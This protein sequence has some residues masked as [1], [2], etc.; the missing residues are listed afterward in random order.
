MALSGRPVRC[1]IVDDSSDFLRAAATV[2]ER[3]GIDVV[4]TAATVAEGMRLAEQ[5]RPDVVLIDV[6]LGDESGFDLAEQLHRRGLLTRS[7]A[8]MTST[9]DSEEFADLISAGPMVGFIPKQ[10]LSAEAIR[11]ARSDQRRE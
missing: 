5:L 9:H 2:L 3:D 8:V 6:Y 7:V 1:L 4:A 10:E 11:V